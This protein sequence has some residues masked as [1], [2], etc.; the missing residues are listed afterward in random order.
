MQQTD[1]AVALGHVAQGLHRQHVVVD[2]QVELLEHGGE[3]ELRGG[4]LVVAGLGG[5]AQ[6]PQL[7]LNVFHEGQHAG[8]DGA[9]VV[10]LQLLVAGGR[11][12]EEGAS[13]LN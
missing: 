6:A 3:L 8:F 2:G 4:D 1:E 11:R 12:A 7:A 13:A 9:K 10:I 5:D